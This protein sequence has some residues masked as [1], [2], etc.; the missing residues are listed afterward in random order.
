MLA[1]FA[2][3]DDET[4]S[5]GGTL[6]ALADHGIPCHLYCATDGDAGRSSGVPVSSRAELGAIRRNELHTAAT[7]L[8]IQSVTCG[9]W[10]DGALATTNPDVVVAE[11]VREIRR[12]RPAVVITF[13]PEGAPTG[14]RDHRAISRMAT[15]AFFLAS[16]PSASPEHGE[17]FAATQLLYFTWPPYPPAE[18][19]MQGMEP[20]HLTVDVREYREVRRHAFL[21]DRTQREHEPIFERIANMDSE[22]FYLAASR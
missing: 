2:H 22:S 3:P 12:L 19:L 6:R 11:I 18:K 10:P 4:F 20:F 13:G 5:I 16:N 1:V 7:I 8:G 21:A 9:G 15:A 17:P 14:H